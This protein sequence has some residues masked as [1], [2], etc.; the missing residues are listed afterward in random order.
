MKSMLFLVGLAYSVVTSASEPTRTY[1]IVSEVE[2]GEQSFFCFQPEEVVSPFRTKPE[3]IVCLALLVG[4]WEMP[5]LPKLN[6]PDWY[7]VQYGQ[8]VSRVH[9][10]YREM[11]K[12]SDSFEKAKARRLYYLTIKERQDRY[13]QAR[14]HYQQAVEY[15]IVQYDAYNEAINPDSVKKIHS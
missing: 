7:R 13:K 3:K 14:K 8:S 2:A 9:V 6:S 12:R 15:M 4:K 5:V 10:A 1:D 11:C